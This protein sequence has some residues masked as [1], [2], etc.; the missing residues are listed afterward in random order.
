MEPTV[1]LKRLAETIFA[2]GGNRNVLYTRKI[3]RMLLFT[4]SDQSARKAKIMHLENLAHYHIH[5]PLIIVDQ[6]GGISLKYGGVG[7][8]SL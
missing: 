7:A 5:S 2:I 6:N 8:L 3:S 1:K 4:V